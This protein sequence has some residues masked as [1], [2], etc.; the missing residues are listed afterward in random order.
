MKVITLFL[1]LL[2]SG[3][4][5]ANGSPPD[6]EYWY[7]NGH[8]LSSEDAGFC[9]KK[10]FENLGERYDVLYKK[11]KQ[12]GFEEFYKNKEEFQEYNLFLDKAFN[13]KSQCYYD[14]GYRFNAPYYWCVVESN[15]RICKENQ[16]YRY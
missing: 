7:K 13:K 4:Y 16:K 12:I 1:T 10:A 8:R 6:T 5:L 11:R 14:L 9:A 15:M 3:C 2:I